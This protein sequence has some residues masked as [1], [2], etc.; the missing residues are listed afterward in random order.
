MLAY[1]FWNAA[2]ARVGANRAGIFLHLV[3]LFGTVL[4]ALFLGERLMWYHYAGAALIFAG[5]YAASRPPR[6]S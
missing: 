2:V 1:F 6:R 3:P 5:I 4:S